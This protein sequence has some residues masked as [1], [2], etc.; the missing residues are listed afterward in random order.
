MRGDVVS[1]RFCFFHWSFWCSLQILLLIKTCGRFTLH[2]LGGLLAWWCL[3]QVGLVWESLNDRKC[4]SL[5]GV[6]NREPILHGSKATVRPF[7]LTFI[8]WILQLSSGSPTPRGTSYLEQPKS[9][10]FHY[11]LLSVWRALTSFHTC[12]TGNCEPWSLRLVKSPHGAN[13][14]LFLISV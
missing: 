1:F 7:A 11:C 3:L 12:L 8:P 2:N 6:C 9:F 10:F 4:L 14:D 5:L 13:V